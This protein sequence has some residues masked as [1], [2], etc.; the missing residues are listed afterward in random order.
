MKVTGALLL[1]ALS[2]NKDFD[3]EDEI[4]CER[5]GA[6][7]FVAV[8]ESLFFFRMISVDMTDGK[9]SPSDGA[10]DKVEDSGGS[11]VVDVKVGIGILMKRMKF[12]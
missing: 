3:D 7:K 1:L 4:L 5:E 2:W 12:W 10:E 8:N 6:V 9:N 11:V